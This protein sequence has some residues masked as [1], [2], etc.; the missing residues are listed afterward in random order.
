M[1]SANTYICYILIVN[2]LI[3]VVNNMQIFVCFAYIKHAKIFCYNI[4][5]EAP[6]QQ[7]NF[8]GLQ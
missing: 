5:N 4:V 7:L 3:F 2:V 1:P 6:E 8:D